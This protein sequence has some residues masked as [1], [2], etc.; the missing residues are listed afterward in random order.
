MSDGKT[1][2]LR[3]TYFSKKKTKKTKQKLPDARKHQIVSFIKSFIRLTACGFGFFGMFELGFI[4]L[5]LA[6][7]VG[8]GEELV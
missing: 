5:F 8:I 6:E 4:W 2:A 1:E 7:L 3:G